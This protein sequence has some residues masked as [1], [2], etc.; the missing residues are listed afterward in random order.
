MTCML[1]LPLK[2][3]C[4]LTYKQQFRVIESD[5]SSFIIKARNRLQEIDFHQRSSGCAGAGGP[6][7][8][9]PR[10]RSE[11]AELRR[12]PLSKERGSGCTLLEQP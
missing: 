4:L 6:R 9:T 3:T 2:E 5:D 11:G 7:G 1:L 10:S 8:A 12:Y